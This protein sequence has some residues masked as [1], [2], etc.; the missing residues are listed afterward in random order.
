MKGTAPLAKVL[1]GRAW[2]PIWGVVHHVGRRSGRRYAVPVALVP[3][4]RAD[5]VLIGLP[6]G[7]GTNWTQNVLAA[8]QATLTWKGRDWLVDGPRLA[9]VAEATAITRAPLRWLVASHRS[10]PGAPAEG[11]TREV[12]HSV[13]R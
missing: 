10:E 3:V 11:L 7:S 5:I 9:G 12:A 2:F 13:R 8:G 1:A 6:W 4:V